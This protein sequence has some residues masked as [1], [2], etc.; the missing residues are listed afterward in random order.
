MKLKLLSILTVFPLILGMSA[1][2]SPPAPKD[3]PLRYAKIQVQATKIYKEQQADGTYTYKT[4][5]ICDRKGQAP[6]FDSSAK[7][8]D[9]DASQ[10]LTCDTNLKIGASR[11]MLMGYVA[12]LKQTDMFGDGQ[13]DDYKS[14]GATVW[15]QTASGSFAKALPVPIS[16]T[17][18]TARKM[19]LNVWGENLSSDQDG[20][21]VLEERINVIFKFE[22]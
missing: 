9:I 5:V 16:A 10:F 19:V 12:E 4:E 7:N 3:K 1:H 22:D 21:R 20:D 13:V 18:P 2:A 6:V 11:L 14:F 17:E 15:I 8:P